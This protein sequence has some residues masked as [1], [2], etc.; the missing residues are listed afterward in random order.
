MSGWQPIETAPKIN[1][2]EIL[3]WLAYSALEAKRCGK[4]G[5]IEVARWSDWIGAWLLD[6]DASDEM[7]PITLWHAPPSPPPLTGEAR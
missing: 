2:Q 4:P 3:A 1:G 7:H 5:R 6:D